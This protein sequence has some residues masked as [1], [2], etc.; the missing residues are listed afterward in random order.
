MLQSLLFFEG[1]I[2]LYPAASLVGGRGAVL[3]WVTQWGRG[4]G[5]GGWFP[6][7]GPVPAL[8]LLLGDPGSDVPPPGGP[9]VPPLPGRPAPARAVS[10]L[11][12]ASLWW[13]L[14]HFGCVNTETW[15]T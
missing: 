3:V 1:F 11:A 6:S 7:G 8:K 12:V 13:N 2:C 15:A 5:A 10:L 14:P 4:P 9:A